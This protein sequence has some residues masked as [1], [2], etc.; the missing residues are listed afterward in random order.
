MPSTARANTAVSR[1]QRR[2]PWKTGNRLVAGVLSLWLLCL[3]SRNL[4]AAPAITQ[5]PIPATANVCMACHGA[6][7]AGNA[8][9]I[10]R[11]AGMDADYLSHALS[12]FRSGT[13]S[14]EAMQPVAR[15]LS[16][17]EINVLAKY[18]SVLNPPLAPS[19]HTPSPDALATGKALALRGDQNSVPACFGCHAANGAG[20]G[21]RYPRI[22]GE[23]AAYVIKRLHDFQARARLQAPKPG[24]MTEVASRLT[25][26]QVV[27]VAAYLSVES[28]Q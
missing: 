13:R 6:E 3:F 15:T 5:P 16:D 14:S 17:E 1:I 26:A 2:H 27:D 8:S 21:E 9:G 24:S 25:E 22:A 11:I 12:A 19:S 18:F 10:P 4:T 7:G 28:P 23:P 20:S